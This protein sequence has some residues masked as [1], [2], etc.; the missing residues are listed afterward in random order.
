MNSLSLRIST[1]KNEGKVKR[2]MKRS[3]Q[4]RIDLVKIEIERDFTKGLKFRLKFNATLNMNLNKL[5]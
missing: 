5:L 3:D 2:S 4:E 1:V